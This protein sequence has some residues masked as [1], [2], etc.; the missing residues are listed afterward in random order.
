MK[1]KKKNTG[2]TVVIV[3]I[4]VII[5]LGL[6]GAYLWK[7]NKLGQNLSLIHI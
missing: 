6:A 3:I 5:L 1:M 2:N 4:I 7:E